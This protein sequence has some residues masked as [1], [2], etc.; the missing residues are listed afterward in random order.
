MNQNHSYFIGIS[1]ALIVGVFSLTHFLYA[2]TGTTDTTSTAS[3]TTTTSTATTTTSETTTL[4]NTTYV[5]IIP[6][7][8]KLD[9][10]AIMYL[11]VGATY[12]EY[13]ALAYDNR[14][15]DISTRIVHES[16]LNTSLP[17]VYNVVYFVRD[18]AGNSAKT[19]R[20]VYVVAPPPP[21]ATQV[22][23]TAVTPTEPIKT[24]ITSGIATF[25]PIRSLTPTTTPNDS[26]EAQTNRLLEILRQGNIQRIEEEKKRIIRN[27]T[28]SPKIPP[29]IATT[30]PQATLVYESPEIVQQKV[31]KVRERSQ[32]A[33]DET[34]IDSDHDGISDYDEKYIYG[35][36]P[37]SADTDGDGYSDRAEITTGFDPKNPDLHAT[38][39]YENPKDS[40]EVKKDILTVAAIAVTETKTEGEKQT[41]SKVEFKGKGLPNSFVT[42]YIFSTP[43][44]VTVK[45][46]SEGNWEYTLDKELVDGNHEM[47]VA[48]TDNAGKILAK[49]SAI[50][51]IKE[52]NAIT[53]DQNFLTPISGGKSPGLLW[54]EYMYATVT[55][56]LCAIGIVFAIIGIRAQ[57]SYRRYRNPADTNDGM[58]DG[59]DH[60]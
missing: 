3:F 10:D 15:G 24:N 11:K 47:Y 6:P 43:T 19:A 4:S 58:G 22:E 13:G 31:Q 52:A 37:N 34:K 56:I 30:F 32:Q 14:D 8:I 23:P 9:G 16:N 29:T 53:V 60:A 21:I 38:I 39:V 2:Q 57:P 26:I 50:P 46:D 17:G 48:M 55:V 5:D 12:V 54:G 51:F 49:S 20:M 59:N 25:T 18:R 41:A 28:P 36:N 45:T 27:A 7:V 35:T 40:G 1:L 33:I 42:V 44:V